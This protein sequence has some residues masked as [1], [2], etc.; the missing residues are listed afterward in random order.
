MN[1]TFLVELSISSTGANLRTQNF[2]VPITIK[3]EQVPMPWFILRYPA[4]HHLYLRNQA[5]RI[6]TAM[7]HIYAVAHV[8]Y[9]PNGRAT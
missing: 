5:Q 3:L 1:H 9:E 8:G 2:T 7:S 4:H 6:P